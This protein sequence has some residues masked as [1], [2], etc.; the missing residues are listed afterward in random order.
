MHEWCIFAGV[1]LHV[2]VHVHV[3]I[4]VSELGALPFA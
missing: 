3:T 2:H 4:L 1:D